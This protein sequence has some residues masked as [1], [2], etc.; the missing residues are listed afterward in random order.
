MFYVYYSKVR[1]ILL[2]PD[3]LTLFFLLIIYSRRGGLKKK[4]FMTIFASVLMLAELKAET[5]INKK[6]ET[7]IHYDNANSGFKYCFRGI[8]SYEVGV[9]FIPSKLK[10]F[11]GE[12]I[13]RIRVFIYELPSTLSLKIYNGLYLNEKTLIYRQEIKNIKPYSWN[14]IRLDVPVTIN[15]D[16]LWLGLSIKPGGYS[17]PVVGLDSGPG[18]FQANLYSTGDSWEHLDIDKNWNIQIVI[19]D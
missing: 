10:T 7:L 8:K 15:D 18:F 19:T 2:A 11:R 17:K 16:D 9:H 3:A 6:G 1:V 13:S 14:E 4:Y 5:I 12:K